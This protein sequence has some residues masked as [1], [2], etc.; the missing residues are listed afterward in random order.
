MK[1][2]LLAIGRKAE[3]FFKDLLKKNLILQKEAGVQNRKSGGILQ[4]E[5]SSDGL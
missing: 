1:L 2:H 4:G 5:E 3:N